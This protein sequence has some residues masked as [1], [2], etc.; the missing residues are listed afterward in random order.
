MVVVLVT[1]MLGAESNI[2]ATGK[3]HLVQ[4]ATIIGRS[5]AVLPVHLVADAITVATIGACIVRISAG[6]S[7]IMDTAERRSEERLPI[8]EK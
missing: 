1:T 3:M 2:A 5:L 8:R 6:A 7:S 4:E